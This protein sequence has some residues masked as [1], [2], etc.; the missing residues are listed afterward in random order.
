MGQSLLYKSRVSWSRRYLR[1]NY[2]YICTLTK[3]KKEERKKLESRIQNIFEIL[4]DSSSSPVV[5][6]SHFQ[7]MGL[8]LCHSTYMLRT[9]ELVALRGQ[10]LGLFRPPL[11]FIVFML[12]ESEGTLSR[13]GIWITSYDQR[14]VGPIV[15]IHVFQRSVCCG[16]ISS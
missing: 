5:C 1:D 11:D 9:G 13:S 12:D 7:R 15:G 2:L 6:R 4:V 8:L 10:R 16:A 3:K 14:R